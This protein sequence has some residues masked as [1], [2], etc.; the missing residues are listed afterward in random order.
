MSTKEE[1]I[2]QDT[3][4]LLNEYRQTLIQSANP[5]SIDEHLMHLYGG[6]RYVDNFYEYD[7]ACIGLLQALCFPEI[8]QKMLETMGEFSFKSLTKLIG[9]FLDFN[10]I[11]Q[12]E[13]FDLM[14]LAACLEYN[15]SDYSVEEC[16]NIQKAMDDLSQLSTKMA[17]S[18]KFY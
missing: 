8:H 1:K 10:K 16:K 9:R 7:S 17:I 12:L 4:E 15:S 11:M 14:F 5:G 2:R 6:P 13:G 3:I 18:R